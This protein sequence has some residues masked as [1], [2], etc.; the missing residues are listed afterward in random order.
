MKN[1]LLNLSRHNK[2]LLLL[3]VDV[4]TISV[5]LWLSFV[6]RQDNIF[7]FSEGYELTGAKP[8]DLYLTQALALII[9]ITSLIISRLYRSIIRY[10]T[11][12]T[13][14]KIAKA[15]LI[16]TLIWS[17]V[18][19]IILDLPIPRSVGLIFF[20]LSTSFL[21][22]TRYTARTFLTKQRIAQMHKVLI[23]GTSPESIE[24]SEILKTDTDIIP[25]G[26]ITS[27]DELKRMIISGLH[28]YNIKD[29]H[30]I[31]DQKNIKEILI[32]SANQKRNK[33][34]NIYNNIKPFQK[35]IRKVPNI[36]ELTTGKTKLSQIKKINIEDL[37]GRD[38]VLPD[39]YLLKAC[40]EN[41][42][43]L[44]TGAGGSIGSE[45]ARHI[46]NLN[47]KKIILIDHS[48]YLLYEIDRELC[49]RNMQKKLSVEIK[50]Y[51]GSVN[52]EDFIKSIFNNEKIN[53]I[54]HAAANKHVPLVEHNP[55]AAIRTNI[56]GTYIVANHS[57]KNSVEN[58]VLIS[59]DKAVRPANIMGATKRL[60]ELIL[61]SLQDV[62]D[63]LPAVKTK[64]KFCMVRFGNVLDT[65]G[66]VVPLFK[67]Q[68]ESGVPVTVTH[69]EVIRYFM[70]IREATELVIQAGSL[71]KGGEVFLLDMGDPIN[72][73]DLAKEMIK[74][75]G[76]EIIDENNPSG[77][78]KIE[79]TGL[80]DGEKLYEELLIGDNVS[81]TA[82]QHIM[83]ANEEKLDHDKI[84]SIIEKLQKFTS[85]TSIT[86]IK[87]ILY[88][89]VSGY[90]P[91]KSEKVVQLKRD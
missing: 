33:L 61:Q 47:P 26:Y 16:G 60:S 80:R 34:R 78:I 82:H 79:F 7:S 65:S 42:N 69:P 18:I 28:V 23:Y 2:R 19:Y 22:F 81:K 70:T 53:T 46:I 51:L 55:L 40:I 32:T 41:K 37:L 27:D 58:F 21:F 85:K 45:M 62:V 56:L 71:S 50:S 89:S 88:D 14:V 66:S 3:F 17:S 75:S 52:D 68:I 59:S 39:S 90:K 83:S 74:L 15:S 77:D 9:I 24:I 67:K 25:V 87:N 8:S 73:L 11:I 49:D 4:I 29:I 54:Y 10:I 1:F 31:I 6:I 13:Y 48:E 76:K 36:K 35:L 64:T 44:I 20:V 38:A 5:A 72:I 57:Y 43:I 63:N 91:Y 30:K 86:E 12:E 84:I